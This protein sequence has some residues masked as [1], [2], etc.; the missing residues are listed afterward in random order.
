M[1]HNYSIG[2]FNNSIYIDIPV[3][4]NFESEFLKQLALEKQDEV[5]S[6]IPL[7]HLQEDEHKLIESGRYYSQKNE[8]G[9][10]LSVH[11]SNHSVSFATSKVINGE[12]NL[13]RLYYEIYTNVISFRWNKNK[14]NESTHYQKL[15]K[16]IRTP[17]KTKEQIISEEDLNKGVTDILDEIK[18]FVGLNELLNFEEI[19]E[20]IW[21]N[22]RGKTR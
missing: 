18:D 10:K 11:I 9:S 20:E 22:L 15:Y 8:D 13:K 17:I 19:K 6:T 5:L 2:K 21:K 1:R 3:Q 14:P 7:A 16:N 12:L 4:I